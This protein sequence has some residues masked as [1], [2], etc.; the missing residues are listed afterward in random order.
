MTDRSDASDETSGTRRYP[1]GRR[2][3]ICAAEFPPLGGGGVLRVAKLARYLPTFGWQLTV[4]CSDEPLGE[5]VDATLLEDIPATVR[6]VR[7]R[8]PFGR[9]AAQVTAGTKTRLKRRS[10]LFGL[11]IATRSAFRAA[12]AIPDRWLPWAATLARRS[13]DDLG[14][15]DV[16]VT[17]GPPHSVHLAGAVLAGRLRVPLVMDLRDEWSL[18]PLMRS[19]LPWRRIIDQRAEQ[20]CLHRAAQL[21]V[22]SDASARRYA[23]RYS[24]LA[25]RISVIPNGFDPAD[26]P[27]PASTGDGR[28][29]VVPGGGAAERAKGPIRYARGVL[30]GGGEPCRTDDPR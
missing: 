29:D 3:L 7:I 22:V 1:T 4:V 27:D 25:G 17:S 10:R 15:P 5:A 14:R 13:A 9:I 6:I 2:A 11:L 8:P 12:V 16:I 26:L 21:V 23:A 20:W 30:T 19:R 18:R 28:A 24:W